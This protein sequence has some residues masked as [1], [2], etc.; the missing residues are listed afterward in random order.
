MTTENKGQI[1]KTQSTE[2]TKDYSNVTKTTVAVDD[3]CYL[4]NRYV[5]QKMYDEAV[6][7][8]E[9]ASKLFPENLALKINLGRVKNLKNQELSKVE[10]IVQKQK[11][12]DKKKKTFFNKF[13]GLGEIYSKMGR[14]SSAKH[15]FE[16]TKISNPD[17]YIPY[18][19]LGKIFYEQK[20]YKKAL[21]ELEKCTK[22]NPFNEEAYNILSLSYFYNGEYHKALIAMVDALIL[23]G[24]LIKE[25]PTSY[26]QKINLIIQKIDGFTPQMRN[27]LIKTRKDKLNTLY[28]EMEQDIRDLVKERSRIVFTK[29]EERVL[30]EEDENLFD[31]ALSLKNN[32]LFKTLDDDTLIELARFTTKI[33]YI[34]DDA[35][36]LDNTDIEGLYVV[37]EGK[38]QIRKETPFGFL[39]FNNF[40]KGSFFGEHDLLRGTK[41][42]AKAVAIDDSTILLL[43]RGGFPALFARHKHTAIHFLWY[44]WKSLSFQIRESNNK[45]KEFFEIMSQ[46]KNEDIIVKGKTKQE[47]L[48]DINKKIEAL[49]GKGLSP[50]EMRLLAAFSDAQ[51]FNAGEHIFKEGESG[52]KLFILIEG[53]VL[54][55]KNIPGIGEEAL[56]VLKRG[57]FFGEMA[58]LGEENKRSADAK[59]TTQKVKLIGIKKEALKEILSIDNESAYQFLTILCKILSF[60]LEAINEKIYQWK[61]MQGGF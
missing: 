8:Y 45:L 7:I 5:D 11:A 37:L 12:E 27:Q 58:L 34:K 21:Q 32:L 10:N 28:E 3:L 1:D 43:N 16:L 31:I 48:V 2:F 40:E 39:V 22:L 46:A 4:A 53:E 14:I 50:M 6:N 17:F 59:A 38:V 56:A 42:W 33:E 51:E 13:Q 25:V 36:Y 29:P 20:E 30:K 47:V 54:I 19:N 15:I 55:S 41:H 24:D 49:E 26:Q 61:M 9:T 52:D 23:S 35:I 18:L 44:F 60:R 57:E